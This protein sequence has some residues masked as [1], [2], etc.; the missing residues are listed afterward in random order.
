MAVIVFVCRP[1][2][3]PQSILKLLSPFLLVED[4]NR[5][6]SSRLGRQVGI[7]HLFES[8]HDDS[9]R[10]IIKYALYSHFYGQETAPE[11]CAVSSF[12]VAFNSHHRRNESGGG[13]IRDD[14]GGESAAAQV[15]R[16]QNYVRAMCI[17]TLST[18]EDLDARSGTRRNHRSE[19]LI[20]V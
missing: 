10:I 18:A 20:R 9:N 2:F 15:D 11:V 7:I 6:P 5:D 4:L 1:K 13:T 3:P 12:A 19:S 8:T 17:A 16:F 14:A